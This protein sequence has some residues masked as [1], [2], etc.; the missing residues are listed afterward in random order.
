MSFIWPSML[1]GL[2]V[3]PVLVALYVWLLRRRSRSAVRYAGLGLV[4]EA[5][6]AGQGIRRHLPPALFLIALGLMLVAAAR[7]TAVVTLPF[8]HET[9]VLAMDVSGSMR[10]ADVAPSR[11]VAA[12]EA[13]RAFIA[14]QPRST[15]I[16][17]VT[18]GG[19]A[20]LIQ[21][22]T[23]DRTELLAAL[24][25]FDFQRGTAV[26]SGLLVSLKTIFPE[27]EIDLSRRDPRPG[28]GPRSGASGARSG[29]GGVP[30]GTAPSLPG[31]SSTPDT[32]APTV[33]PGSYTSAVIILLTDGQTTTGPDPIAAAWMAAERGVR[34]YT[35]GVGTPNGEIL[36]G[37]GWSM[38]VRLDEEA[39]K[40]IAAITL[41][42]Y[43]HAGTAEDLKKV[44]ESLTSQIALE[45]GETEVTAL[46]TA[47]AALLMILSALL[48][49][50]WFKRVL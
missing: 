43:F 22:P 5:M 16:G 11:M 12:Q 31:T 41:G 25:R 15:R 35:V 42:E 45:T 37:D 48:S 29:P 9:V 13:A 3:L 36:V 50:I 21:P 49:L 26:G 28:A 17:V 18:F 19:S 34:V 39:L 27:I 33:P 6:S 38:R 10:A 20:A 8:A 32:A 47:G 24:E 44:Y 4:R 7:P 2:A 1:A 40:A 30:G 46:F 14:A 23:D